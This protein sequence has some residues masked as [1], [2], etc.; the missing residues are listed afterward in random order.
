MTVLLEATSPG[1][2]NAA[3]FILFLGGLALIGGWL[4]QLT[5]SA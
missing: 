1:L 5:R 4:Q 2:I 3:G